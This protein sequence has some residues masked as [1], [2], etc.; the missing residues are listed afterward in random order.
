MNSISHSTERDEILPTPPSAK[1]R[2]LD[3]QASPTSSD[4]TDPLD[5][6]SPHAI[7]FHTSQ[8]ASQPPS[9]ARSASVNSQVSGRPA[10]SLLPMK[11]NG[12][13]E[14]RLVEKRMDSKPKTKRQLH[15]ENRNYPG[16][17]VLL[18]SSPQ[19]RS[20]MSNPI[21]ISGDE[22]QLIKTSSKE[23]SCPVYRGTARQPPRT[24]NVTNSNTSESLK[25]RAKL[26]QSPYFD[27]Y[28][29]TTSR[30]NGNVKHKIRETT[31]G[32][33]Q[34]FVAADGR[35]RGS[36]VNASSDADE[37]QSA[38]TTVGQNADP[39]AV[40]NFKDMGSNSPS[41]QSTSVLKA[42]IPTDDLAVLAPSI[43]KS[44]FASSN[45]KSRSSGRPTHPA[46]RDQEAKPLWA[47]ALTAIN[48]PGSLIK[49]DDL[50]LV[51]DRK[52]KEYYIERSG[53]AIYSTH[54]SLRIRPQKL[55]KV[56]WEK[57]GQRVRLES[58]RS[59]MEDNVLELEFAHERDVLDLLRRLQTSNSF[60][61]IG[62]TRYVLVLT[63]E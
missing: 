26:T 47:V 5:Q 24:S 45:V 12:S 53:L 23:V 46:P 2:K 59:G 38:P 16:D 14:Y 10:A 21:D 55:V 11:R 3:R 34:K 49:H 7:S 57:L 50:N 41:K 13:F 44:D 58:S 8:E 40:F 29:H 61:V 60:S 39:E 30:A 42:S 20:S 18:P 51:Y 35:R 27:K 36:D 4:Q 32:L 19:N 6:Y 22:S 1:R 25:E 15:N 31:P 52:Q 48:F 17:H 56:L 54:S 62:K 9:R 33:A 63:L 43:I 37:L 28:R